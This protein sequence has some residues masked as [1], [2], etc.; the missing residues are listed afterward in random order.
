M[1]DLLI[2]LLH[3]LITIAKLLGPGVL[4]GRSLPEVDRPRRV[5]LIDRYL[6]YVL[7]TLEQHPSLT[8]SRLCDPAATQSPLV[9][10][11]SHGQGEDRRRALLDFSGQ[12]GADLFHEPEGVLRVY[13]A[14]VDVKPRAAVADRDRGDRFAGA[15]FTRA[16]QGG[17][18]GAWSSAAFASRW[19]RI[20][21]MASG[22]SMHFAMIRIAPP[23]AGQASISIPKTR[24]RRCIQ[25]SS[26]ESISISYMH[27]P[28]F[29]SAS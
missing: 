21:S 8:A 19:A 5:S 16:R 12:D 10:P 17:R 1:K 29:A 7:K 4:S 22:S 11:P 13:I 20:F 18:L 14:I 6:P 28:V 26:A 27:F 9:L 23:Q 3:L 25:L 2:L 15:L 24:L